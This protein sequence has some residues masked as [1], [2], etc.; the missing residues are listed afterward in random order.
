MSVNVTQMLA[1][2]AM[3]HDDVTFDALGDTL[4]VTAVSRDAN[5]NPIP[6]SVLPGP[7]WT[8][9]DPS[10]AGDSH[11]SRLARI[12]GRSHGPELED[13]ELPPGTP[14]A[15]VPEEHRAA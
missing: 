4:T 13:D 10:V 12:G 5:G 7:V 2:Y 6:E 9:R 14:D 3:S 15:G 8:S 11:R 1:S